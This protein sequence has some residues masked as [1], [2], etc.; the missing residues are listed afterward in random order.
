MINTKKNVIQNPNTQTKL[1][2]WLKET[3]KDKIKRETEKESISKK[4]YRCYIPTCSFECRSR[5]GISTKIKKKILTHKTL[6][7]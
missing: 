4:C 3:E 2:D 6:G 5:K 1:R 7:I